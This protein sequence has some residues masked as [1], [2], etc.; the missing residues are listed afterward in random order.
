[1]PPTPLP[2]SPSRHVSTSTPPPRRRRDALADVCPPRHAALPRLTERKRRRNLRRAAREN[3]NTGC[4]PAMGWTSPLP[5]VRMRAAMLVSAVVATCRGR[6]RRGAIRE[7]VLADEPHEWFRRSSYEASQPDC[8]RV[9]LLLP[10]ARAQKYNCDDAFCCPARV[11]QPSGIGPTPRRLAH[12]VLPGCGIQTRGV[13][14]GAEHAAVKLKG[15][16]TRRRAP[17]P[18]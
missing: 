10:N 8:L 18:R 5:A 13:A 16:S 6:L 1:M 14:R 15:S 4:D 12:G 17:P 3:F 2:L 11:L 9:G 7:D